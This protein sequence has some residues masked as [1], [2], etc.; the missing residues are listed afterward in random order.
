MVF[1]AA[2]YC[3]VVLVYHVLSLL[4]IALHD[5]FLHLLNSEVDGDNFGNAEECALE[6]G[7][8]AVAKANFLCNLGCIDVVNGDVVLCE[9]ALDV[10]GEVLYEFVAFPDSVEKESTAVAEAAGHI[11]H[12]KVSLYVACHE[13]GGVYQVCG[14]DRLVAETEV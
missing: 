13:V 8:G 14:A 6:N 7:V 2:V 5:E 4:A 11:V 9:V 3:L 12:I 10:V 1:T